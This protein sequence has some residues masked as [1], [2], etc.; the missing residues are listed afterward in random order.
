MDH[1]SE[2]RLRVADDFLAYLSDVESA[3]ATDELL[4]IP[5]L[6]DELRAAQLEAERGEHVPLDDIK[7]K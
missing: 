1:L 6:R 7:W 4:G 3:E 2:E 5:G